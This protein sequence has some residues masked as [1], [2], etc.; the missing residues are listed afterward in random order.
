MSTLNLQVAATADDAVE[1]AAGFVSLTTYFIVVGDYSTIRYTGMRF[2]GVSGLSG[3]TI[4]SAVV[5]LRAYH[6]DTGSFIG[7]CYAHDAAAPGTFTTATNNITDTAQRPRTTAVCQ[8]NSE[9]LGN[10]TAGQ[11]YT[12]PTG[13][14]LIPVIQELA[15]SYDPLAI[16]LLW[17]YT[18][19]SGERTIYAYDQSSATAPKL[20]IDYTAGTADIVVTPTAVATPL[21]VPT[22]TLDMG[23]KTLTPAAVELPLVVPTITVK[24]P[25]TVLTPQPVA[26]QLVVPSAGVTVAT[27]LTPSSVAMPLVVPAITLEFGTKTLTPDP[28]ELS[29]VVP[30]ITVTGIE[31]AIVFAPYMWTRA[32]NPAEFPAGALFHVV[33]MLRTTDAGTPARARL[34]NVTDGLEVAGSELNTTETVLTEVVGPGASLPTGSKLYRVEIG[35]LQ[36]G[37]F[38]CEDAIVKVVSS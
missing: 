18:S 33:V 24:P 30:V 4:D 26:L 8:A 28:V 9:D 14:Q 27:I 5:T 19:G 29:L 6:S 21:A 16:A 37:E 22:V 13:S 12:F 23:T 17:I 20:D 11:D 7:D 10:W 2:T 25:D 32:L 3:A 31:G 34:F 35:G 15:D 38:H 1:F 36:G